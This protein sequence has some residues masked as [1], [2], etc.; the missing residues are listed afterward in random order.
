VYHR[1]KIF[2]ISA[3]KKRNWRLN[4]C[5]VYDAVPADN[6]LSVNTE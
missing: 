6:Y 5:P 4:A 1:S 2:I 3:N